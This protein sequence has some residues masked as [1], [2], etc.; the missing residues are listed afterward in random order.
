[1]LLVFLAPVLI[2]TGFFCGLA[3]PPQYAAS[4]VAWR[5]DQV[6]PYMLAARRYAGATVS[7]L[8]EASNA[9]PYDAGQWIAAPAPPPPPHPSCSCV[10][11]DIGVERSPHTNISSGSFDNISIGIEAP[12]ELEA[13]QSFFAA[14]PAPSATPT[15]MQHS[16]AKHAL[17]LSVWTF[18]RSVLVVACGALG[19]NG[20][21]VAQ[22]IALLQARARGLLRSAF[23]ARTTSTGVADPRLIVDLPTTG[24]DTQ[25]D[26][27]VALPS[28]SQAV[29]TQTKLPTAL[30]H[31]HTALPFDFMSKPATADERRHARSWAKRRISLV[32]SSRQKPRVV[33]QA[34][35]LL[36][37]MA[38]A[39]ASSGSASGTGNGAARKAR[40]PVHARSPLGEISVNV[41]GGAGPS[42]SGSGAGPSGAKTGADWNGKRRTACFYFFY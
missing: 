38:A 25:L 33:G 4:A 15:A 42:A 20:A 14:V 28:P 23:P 18:I 41:D 31:G 24:S 13:P 6:D 39:K 34:R 10:P 29:I 36:P 9:A 37:R 11:L 19:A 32:D 17:L 7:I 1:M 16:P 8:R 40:L 21:F 12:M 30:I 2:M 22:V 3:A 5:Q 27:L 26:R 35:S